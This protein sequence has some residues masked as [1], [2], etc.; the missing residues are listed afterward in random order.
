MLTQ[1]QVRRAVATAVAMTRSHHQLEPL[2]KHIGHLPSTSFRRVLKSTNMG[3]N[4]PGISGTVP[5]LIYLSSA[6][7]KGTQVTEIPVLETA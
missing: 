2:S 4:H 7:D 6:M 5:D 3:S 1:T